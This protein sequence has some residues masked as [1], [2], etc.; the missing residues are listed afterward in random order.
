MKIGIVT[1]P[2]H[3]N[4]GGIL[5][6][7]ALQT[8]L[9]RMGHDVKVIDRDFK[10]RISDWFF[11]YPKRILKK[12]VLKKN[13]PIFH[14][15]LQYASYLNNTVHTRSFMEKYIKR[16][17]VRNLS[18]I[19]KKEFDAYVFGSDQIWRPIYITQFYPKVTD[20]FGQFANNWNVVRLSYAASFGVDDLGEFSNS[21]IEEVKKELHHF[22]AVSVRESDGVNICKKY[23]DIDAIHVLDPTLLI[24]KE[25]Y[26]NLVDSIPVSKNGILEY[27]LDPDTE[28]ETIVK[29]LQTN[30]DES[31][32]SL[33][34]HGKSQVSVEEWIAGFRDAKMVVTDSFHACVF[35]IIFQKPF[36]VI[37]NPTRGFSRIKSLLEMFNLQHHLITEISQ[38]KSIDSYKIDSSVYNS[39]V[40]WQSKS[41]H[42]L[43]SALTKY[44]N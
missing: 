43:I 44:K 5:Q 38:I 42:F 29:N 22:N 8:V 17:L 1:L 19:K 18:D 4:Y 7:W 39:L 35:S 37:A 14:E 6:A 13:I 16:R 26:L 20:A 24:S 33:L 2:L 25:E 41:T 12:Y 11:L 32:Y 28:K 23:F 15:K 34:S 40:S 31:I 10:S 21:E 3:S 9:T 27:I 36:I 30:F